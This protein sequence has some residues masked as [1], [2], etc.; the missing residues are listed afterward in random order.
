MVCFYLFIQGLF[1][2]TIPLFPGYFYDINNYV[3]KLIYMMCVCSYIIPYSA[4][5]IY[6]EVRPIL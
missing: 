2:N 4:G 3:K 6:G 1:D 5:L